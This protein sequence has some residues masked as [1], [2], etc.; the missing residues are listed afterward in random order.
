[1]PQ[2]GRSQITPPQMTPQEIAAHSPSQASVAGKLHIQP[3]HAQNPITHVQ[4][5]GLAWGVPYH[6]AP[7]SLP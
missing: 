5:Q 2:N 4:L 3:P 7:L 1:M 6:G